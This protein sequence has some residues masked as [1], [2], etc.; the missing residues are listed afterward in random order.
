MELPDENVD[1]TKV[2]C[3]YYSDELSFHQSTTS[4]KYYHFAKQIFSDVS[5]D[6]N[7]N[8]LAECSQGEF[9]NKI[10]IF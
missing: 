3:I 5:K 6:A 4:L 2:V 9:A 10:T 7:A 1:K 8:T